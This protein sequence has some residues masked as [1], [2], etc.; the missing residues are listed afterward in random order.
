MLFN[1]LAFLIFF[2]V[3]TGLYFA[4]PWRARTYMLVFASTVF[5]MAFI[6]RYVLII[7]F[8]IVVDFAAGLLIASSSGR[9][10]KAFLL[11]S[12]V[13]NVGVLAIFKYWN[14]AATNLSLLATNLGIERSFPS[15]DII[16][17]IG[18]SFHTFQAMSYTIEVYRGRQQVERDF[19][20]YTLYVLYYPQLVAGPIER[21]QNI[22]AQ[23]RQTH[24]FDGERVTRGLRRMLWGFFKKIVVADRLALA[25]NTIYSDPRAHPGPSLVLAT[26]FFS[27]QIYADFSGYSDIALGA[28]EVMGIKLMTNFREPY[29]AASVTEFWNRWHISLSTWF[30]DYVYI[31]L[32]GNRAGPV[33]RR[34]NLMATFALSGLWHGANWTYVL[35]GLLNGAFLVV[36][37]GRGSR[38]IRQRS[39]P[40]VA[41]TFALVSFAWIFFRARTVS[42]A[43]YISAHLTSGW[44]AINPTSPLAWIAR[45]MGSTLPRLVVTVCALAVLVCAD[46][47]ARARRSD[48]VDL[49]SALPAGA[50]WALYYTVTAAIVGLGQYGQQQF[51]YFQF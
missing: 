34:A 19:L 16:L 39:T 49:V 2:P 1:S 35:W 3:V 25:V 30:R 26:V 33:R 46:W 17:P 10:R 50:R 38:V 6:P 21:P 31:P 47:W 32:G 37:R 42:D 11:L 9:R 8:T 13:A 27:Y 5:Y 22:L 41:L 4:L 18:L 51:I 44:A 14:F 12:I 36:E 24:R 7:Y 40:R 20:V 48:P 15:L 45:E 29:T 28:S 43:F 23:L